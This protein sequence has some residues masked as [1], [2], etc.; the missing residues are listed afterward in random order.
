MAAIAVPAPARVSRVF[1]DQC[2]IRTLLVGPGGVTAGNVVAVTAAGRVVRCNT[3]TAGK[4]Q[5]RGIALETLGEGQGVD[6]LEEG[7]VAGFDLS[8]LAYDALVYAQD[9]DGAAG[10]AP[11]TKAVPIGRVVPLAD[12]DAAGNPSK[13]LYA[14]F[15]ATTNY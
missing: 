3:A 2:R 1:S 14:R 13:V 15:S 6:V 11:G 9:S 12:R 7:F 8:G 10:D 5:A 4:Q